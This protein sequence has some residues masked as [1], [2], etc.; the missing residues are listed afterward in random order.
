METKRKT[1][2]GHVVGT[3]MDKTAVVTVATTR[4]HPI[5]KK[6]MRRATRYKVHDEGNRCQLGDKVRIIEVRPIS[7]DKHW[8]IAEII[9]RGQVA[10]IQPKEIALEM[11]QQEE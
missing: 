6:I 9:N 11:E 8:K 4:R 10:E 7:K 2:V 1:R 5:Y 3:K